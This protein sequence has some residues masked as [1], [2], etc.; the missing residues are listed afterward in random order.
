MYNGFASIVA[1]C[2]THPLSLIKAPCI[3]FIDEIDAVGSTRK[4]WEGHRKKTSHKLLVEMDGF[5]QNEG[6]FAHDLKAKT[7]K[8]GSRKGTN[9][10]LFFLGNPNRSSLICESKSHGL[11]PVCTDWIPESALTSVAMPLQLAFVRS[12]ADA[13][14]RLGYVHSL[15]PG[16]RLWACPPV[17]VTSWLAEYEC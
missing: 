6:I 7:T 2:F 17:E 8:P 16:L 5:E 14:A 1:V 10:F 11:A 15:A 12:I 9:F 3:I 4:Q 13:L